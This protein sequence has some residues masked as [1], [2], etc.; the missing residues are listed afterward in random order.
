MALNGKMQRYAEGRASGMDPQTAGAHAGYAPGRGLNVTVSKVEA[1]ADVKAEIKRIKR[2]GV[3]VETEERAGPGRKADWEMKANY[4]DPLALLLDV[5][6]NP[7]APK[8]LRYQAAK[9][10]LA[11][12]H[13]RIA[14]SGKK[15][16]EQEKAEKLSKGGK[17]Q[18]KSA[19][20]RASHAVN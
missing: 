14:E 13:P 3:S 1:R 11:Y 15:E 6:N 19:P 4:K 8:S 7:D 17:Y 12:C 18:R 9:D 16:K 5:M 2:E 10:S 20:Q